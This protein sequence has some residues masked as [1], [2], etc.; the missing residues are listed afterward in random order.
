M[1]GEVDLRI[2]EYWDEDEEGRRERRGGVV[3]IDGGRFG[4]SFVLR[5][6]VSSV[7]VVNRALF[8]GG[9]FRVGDS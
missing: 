9:R 6:P 7:G 4:G 5:F 1:C 2:R 3:A 8:Q